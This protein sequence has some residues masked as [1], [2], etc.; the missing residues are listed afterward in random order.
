MFCTKGSF[1][2]YARK[3]FRKTS[4]SYP[5]LRPRAS[6]YQ[7]VKNASFL[8]GFVYIVTRWSLFCN[9][10]KCY[11]GLSFCCNVHLYSAAKVDSFSTYAKFW[12]FLKP[13]MLLVSFYTPWKHPLTSGSLMFL[14]GKYR[15]QRHEMGWTDFT[16]WCQMNVL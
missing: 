14:G 7:G 4:I 6:A 16:C 12:W 3:I 9:A 15:R 13:F 11:E 5:L 10:S 8:G 2:Y 1:I